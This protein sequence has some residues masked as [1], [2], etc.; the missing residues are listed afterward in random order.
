MKYVGRFLS[1]LALTN[2]LVVCA[3]S[4]LLPEVDGLGRGGHNVKN[5]QDA[6]EEIRSEA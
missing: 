1:A 5:T 2:I 4:T 3:L 6:P